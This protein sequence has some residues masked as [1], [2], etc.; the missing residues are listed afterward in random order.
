MSV[1]RRF[2]HAWRGLLIFV[3]CYIACVCGVCS[4]QKRFA[5]QN[6]RMP[7]ISCLWWQ[8]CVCVYRQNAGYRG[9]R[10]KMGMLSSL[11]N[12]PLNMP[13]N[14]IIHALLYASTI[15]L[16][17]FPFSNTKCYINSIHQPVTTLARITLLILVSGG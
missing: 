14:T 13:Q 10:G 5:K 16:F 11:L 1:L 2:S 17:L 7:K 15:Y 9:K 6:K 4:A 12:I 3:F 8:L